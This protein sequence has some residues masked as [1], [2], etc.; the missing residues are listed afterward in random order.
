MIRQRVR[1][2][3]VINRVLCNYPNLICPWIFMRIRPLIQ[4]L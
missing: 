2:P 3:I 1:Q 4:Q